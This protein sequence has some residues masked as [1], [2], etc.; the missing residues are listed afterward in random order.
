M[1]RVVFLLLLI[2]GATVR[3]DEL[4]K[5][6]QTELKDLGFYYSEIT[7]VNSAETVAAL[8]RYQIRNGLEVT[9]TLTKET[10]AALGIGSGKEPAPAPAPAP[11]RKE[12]PVNL[13]R[14][15]SD[16]EADR[17]FLRREGPPSD[18]DSSAVE[19]PAPLN[20]PA[21]PGS[22]EYASVFART[23]FES[24]PAEVQV[25]TLR[26][27]QLILARAGYYRDPIDGMPGPATE[28]AILSYQR[29]HHLTLTGRLDLDTLGTMAL[30]PGRLQGPPL[31]P[32]SAPPGSRYSPRALRGVWVN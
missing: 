6:V 30:L 32:F 3:A 21:D 14:D 29:R 27:A 1:K 26:K 20:P 24:A 8:R 10:L 22:E 18:R 4:T 15:E 13:R 7:G 19:P 5:R 25:S 16:K 31:R 2:L 28:E 9:G 11:G 23:P 12:P 17:N